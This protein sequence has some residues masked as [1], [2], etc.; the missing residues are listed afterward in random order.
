MPSGLALVE[1]IIQSL[2]G[3]VESLYVQPVA[4]V[5]GVGAA[6]S[7]TGSGPL[8]TGSIIVAANSSSSSSTSSSSTASEGRARGL[9]GRYYC[10]GG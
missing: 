5:T 9:C 1:Q 10:A 3:A 7:T 8:V 4:V 2:E 6:A